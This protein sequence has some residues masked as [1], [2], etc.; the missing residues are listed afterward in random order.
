MKLW[1]GINAKYGANAARFE[2][3]TTRLSTVDTVYC[4]VLCQT[5]C[6]G[7]R[8][9]IKKWAKINERH[10]PDTVGIEGK[11]PRAKIR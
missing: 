1:S 5:K 11:V 10:G 8:A 7:N 4:G 9:C 6:A 3:G 2:G